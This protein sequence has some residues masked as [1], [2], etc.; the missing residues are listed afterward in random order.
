MQWS[1]R[2]MNITQGL[3]TGCSKHQV[4]R[5]KSATADADVHGFGVGLVV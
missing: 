3:F 5:R 1:E 4:P 2:H